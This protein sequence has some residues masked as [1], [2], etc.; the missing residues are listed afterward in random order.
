M[1]QAVAASDRVFF[2]LQRSDLSTFATTNQ[3]SKSTRG[4]AGRHRVN[5]YDF[6]QT[7]EEVTAWPSVGCAD[8]G[9]WCV[10]GQQ[11]AK[12]RPFQCSECR[13]RWIAQVLD[14]RRETATDPLQSA[15]PSL[16]TLTC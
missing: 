4:F 12:R 15:S 13:G 14:L 16:A 1:T 8:C 2:R 9:R 3:K 6:V 7:S 11:S 5:P 10:V